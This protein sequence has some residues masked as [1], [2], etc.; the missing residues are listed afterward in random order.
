MLV[1]LGRLTSDLDLQIRSPCLD[2]QLRPLVRAYR[3]HEQL[4][5]QPL[6][7]RHEYLSQIDK[8]KEGTPR[9]L[10]NIECIHSSKTNV[11]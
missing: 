7:L 4:S 1:E 2:S 11:P 10:I 9:I 3:R 5:R 6:V 8:Q